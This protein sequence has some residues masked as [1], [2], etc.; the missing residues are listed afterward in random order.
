M[1]ADLDRLREA[2]ADLMNIA[3]ELCRLLDDSL[4]EIES[5]PS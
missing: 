1:S 2:F 4:Q 5:P 3:E